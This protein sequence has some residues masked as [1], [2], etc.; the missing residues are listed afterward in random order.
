MISSIYQQ[1]IATNSNRGSRYAQHLFLYR[2]PHTEIAET[3]ANPKT[4]L[5]ALAIAND[6]CYKYHGSNYRWH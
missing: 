6:D 1:A 3:A 2:L 5:Q 4:K